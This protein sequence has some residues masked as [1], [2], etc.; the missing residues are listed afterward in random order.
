MLSLSSSPT[1][2]APSIAHPN[3]RISSKPS[4][5]CIL[6]NADGVSQSPSSRMKN[7]SA[8]RSLASI[9]LN[10]LIPRQKPSAIRLLVP[11]LRMPKLRGI[12]LFVTLGLLMR[13]ATAAQEK[14]ETTN[15]AKEHTD[16]IRRRKII[17]ALEAQRDNNVMSM[18]ESENNRDFIKIFGDMWVTNGREVRAAQRLL[19]KETETAE[20]PQ[21]QEDLDLEFGFREF[22]RFRSFPQQTPTNDEGGLDTNEEHTHRGLEK[23][24][25]MLNRYI[26]LQK[27]VHGIF[28]NFSDQFPRKEL[29]ELIDEVRTVAVT[30]V[31]EEHF[32]KFRTKK[33]IECLENHLHEINRLE[34]EDIYKLMHIKEVRNALTDVEDNDKANY[35]KYERSYNTILR[36]SHSDLFKEYL[37]LQQIRVAL[38]T[39]HQR[40]QCKIDASRLRKTDNV[41][42]G[43]SNEKKKSNIEAIR[44]N[45]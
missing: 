17:D 30:A 29:L 20:L 24:E 5:F 9:P 33:S 2:D 4:E 15:A 16:T 11:D 28:D 43:S 1:E 3:C 38:E 35:K 19:I 37:D 36:H 34:D 25:A 41:L 7:L 8:R 27:K 14:Y 32:R 26:K 39:Y 10:R 42:E 45:G 21:T 18:F 44:C 6:N 31:Q 22:L 12:L 13:E 23:A 40:I